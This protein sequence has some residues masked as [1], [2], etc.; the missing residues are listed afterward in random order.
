MVVAWM[1]VVF[2][3]VFIGLGALNVLVPLDQ[4]C[5]VNERVN[6]ALVLCDAFW[7]SYF[8]ACELIW[9]GCVPLVLVHRPIHT[10]GIV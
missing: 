8:G 3:G 2:D 9:G 6:C 7:A 1:I 4:L 10:C 5:G